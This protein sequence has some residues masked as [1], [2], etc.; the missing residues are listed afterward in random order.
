MTLSK[1]C[2]FEL[3]IHKQTK[4]DSALLKKLRLRPVVHACIP[5]GESLT[6]PGQLGPQ[7]SSKPT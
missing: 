1:S 7:M 5:R 2:N 3:K 6:V 4:N